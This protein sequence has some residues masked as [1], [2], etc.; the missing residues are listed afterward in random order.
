MRPRTPPLLQLRLHQGG[1]G[2]NVLRPVTAVIL[3]IKSFGLA[4]LLLVALL[5]AVTLLHRPPTRPCH[6]CGKRVRLDRRV[7]R[8]CGYEFEPIRWG[9]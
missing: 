6:R 5:V 2:T 9:S 3:N 1:S 4:T 8:N 7:C